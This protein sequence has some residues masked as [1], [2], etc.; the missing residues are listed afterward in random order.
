MSAAKRIKE[1]LRER[2]AELAEY[3]FPNGKR[4][5]NHW[6]VGDVNGTPGK[7]FKI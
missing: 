5:G 2:V 1:L 3:L 6:A 4:D 7:S